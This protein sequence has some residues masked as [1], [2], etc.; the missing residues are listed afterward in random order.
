MYPSDKLPLSRASHSVTVPAG[1]KIHYAISHGFQLLEHC[2]ALHEW[3][4]G[5]FLVNP[6]SKEIVKYLK[7]KG[8]DVKVVELQKIKDNYKGK[9]EHRIVVPSGSDGYVA[10]EGNNAYYTSHG[11]SEKSYYLGTKGSGSAITLTKDYFLEEERGSVAIPLQFSRFKRRT[12]DVTREE[13]YK[14]FKIDRRKPVILYL[15][16]HGT[17][18]SFKWRVFRYLEELKK[19]F[20]VIVKPHALNWVFNAAKIQQIR[21]KFG[22]TILR[23][24][25][26]MPFIEIA[27]VVIGDIGAATTAVTYFPEKPLILLRDEKWK[28]DVTGF[29]MDKREVVVLNKMQV[30]RDRLLIPAIEKELKTPLSKAEARQEYFH[31]WHGKISGWEARD[32]AKRIIEDSPGEFRRKPR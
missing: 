2:L 30:E 12:H 10:L 21:H 4:G 32:Y 24:H 16:T 19:D 13:L 14:H 8:A 15:P 17:F 22:P 25:N 27:D 1:V 28:P 29:C 3:I 31:R 9:P 20:N 7:E 18:C 5:D 11:I 23:W 6:R 26:V